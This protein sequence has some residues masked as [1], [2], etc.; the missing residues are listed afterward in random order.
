VAD[1][2]GSVGSDESPRTSH[3]CIKLSSISIT[4]SW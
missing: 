3:H 1:L 4:L 2:G